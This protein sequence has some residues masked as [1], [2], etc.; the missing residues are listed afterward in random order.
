MKKIILSVLVAFF[1][2]VMVFGQAKRER[3]VKNLFSQIEKTNDDFKKTELANRIQNEMIEILMEADDF[4]YDFP[5]LKNVGKVLSSDE[6]VH[7]YTWNVLLSDGTPQYYALFQHNEFNGI[8]LM[9]KSEPTIPST[10]GYVSEAN[11]YGA[12]YYEIHPIKF[13]DKE[14]YMVFGLMTSTDGETHHKVIDVL[15]FSKKAIKMGAPSFI[16]PWA[17]KKKQHRVIFEYDKNAQLTLDYNKKKKTITFDHLTP[18]RTTADGK[19][20]MGPDMSYDALIYKKDIWSYKEDVKAK[21]KK[22]KKSKK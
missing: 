12:L 1:A 8:Y 20:I 4:Y 13:K 9:S 22:E 18:I 16:T 5:S 15:A 14:M 19:E 7:M 6:Q 11:W 10:S 21:N 3:E 2:T 17:G